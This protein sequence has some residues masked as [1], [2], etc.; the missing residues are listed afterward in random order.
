MA[1]NTAEENQPANPEDFLSN[2]KWPPFLILGAAPFMNIVIAIAFMA[3]TRMVGT[4]TV[5]IPPA[6]RE[7]VPGKPGARAGLVPGGRILGINGEP[8]KEFD[9]M[10]VVIGMQG[11]SA[12]RVDYLRNGE[13]RATTVTP[14]R[15]A[16]E[17]G[18]IGK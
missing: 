10:R 12:L 5:I 18:P 1:G 7:S 13:G 11:G 17:F 8:M 9:D 14:E 3:I 16:S 6:I 4:G 15:E 2:P